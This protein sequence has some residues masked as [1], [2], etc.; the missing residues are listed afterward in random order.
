MAVVQLAWVPTLIVVFVSSGGWRTYGW[1][2]EVLGSFLKDFTTLDH[3]DE[4]SVLRRDKIARVV[5]K[6]FETGL[7]SWRD[8]PNYHL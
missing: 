7:T 1:L 6:G 5:C 8:D 2:I 3:V 4:V